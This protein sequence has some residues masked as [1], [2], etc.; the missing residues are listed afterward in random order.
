MDKPIY[1][2]VDSLKFFVSNIS[3]APLYL[4]VSVTAPK[5]APQAQSLGPIHSA[6]VACVAH[7]APH[8]LLKRGI[9]PAKRTCHIA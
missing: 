9:D 4:E 7:G 5:H 1:R 3:A 8:V 6:H 2:S